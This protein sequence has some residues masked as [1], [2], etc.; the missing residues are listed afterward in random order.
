MKTDEITGS[1]RVS[2]I[3]QLPE[4][5]GEGRL[6][7]HIKTGCEIYHL[8][9]EDKENLFS[10]IFRTIPLNSKGVPH[11]L[12]HSVLSGSEKFPVKDPFV[13]LLKGSM[14]TFLNA[15]TYPDKTIYPGATIVEADYFNL[16]SVYGDAVFFPLL[17]KETFLQEGV[18]IQKNSD[19]TYEYMGVVYNEMKGAYSD[20]NSILAEWS[21]RSLFPDTSYRYDS[22]GMPE[23]IKTLGYQEFIEFHKKN[24]HPSNCKIFLYGN[25]DSEKQLDFIDKKFLSFFDKQEKSASVKAQKYIPEPVYLEKY[26][27]SDDG[28]GTTSIT[29]NWLCGDSTEPFELLSMEILGELLIGS[30]GSP[31]YLSINNSGLGEDL[32][33]VSGMDNGM[34]QTMFSVGIRGT[35]SRKRD[36]FVDLVNNSLI[37]IRDKGFDKDLLEGTLRLFEFSNR[38]IKGGRPEGLKLMELCSKAWLY[39]KDPALFLS[40]TPYMEKIRKTVLED[41][42]Y[43][44]KILNNALIQNNHRSIVTVMPDNA[45]QADISDNATLDIATKQ[46][47]DNDFSEFEKYQLCQ[48][49]AADIGKIPVLKKSDIPEKIETIECEE[50]YD[51]GLCT[52]LHGVHTAGITYTDLYYDTSLLDEELKIYLPIFSRFLRETG[53]PGIPYYE[54][55]KIFGL[56]TGG[57]YASPETGTTVYG[58][59]LEFLTLHFKSLTEKYK[60]AAEFVFNFI[61]NA[62]FDDLGRLKD[63]FKETVNDFKARIIR[64]GNYIASLYASKNYTPSLAKMEEWG[65]I[66][67]LLKLTAIN[68]EDKK[69]LEDLAQKLKKI[70]TIFSSSKVISNITSE[71]N[72]ISDCYKNLL[73]YL[74]SA[75]NGKIGDPIFASGCYTSANAS[76][77]ADNTKSNHLQKELQS[78]TSII[79][80]ALVNY[81]SAVMR[82]SRIGSNEVVYEKLL[83]RIIETGFLWENIRMK[84]GA[85]GVSASSNSM[86]GVFSFSSYRDPHIEETQ[87][88][89][90]ESLNSISASNGTILN[91]DIILKSVINS[92]GKEIRPVSPEEKGIVNALRKIYGVNDDLRQKNRDIM[93]AATTKNILDAANRL[94]AQYEAASRCVI[95]GSDP[96]KKYEKYFI[97][98]KFEKIE[99]EI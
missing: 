51:N 50:K 20:H 56:K 78:K 19:G 53:L 43:F 28:K 97:Q 38:E 34:Y 7:T 5:N 72:S 9:N 94:K 32:S 87:K 95:A 64:R 33:P 77:T 98:N 37:E 71:E 63:I 16:M 62:D 35:D 76:K 46:E 55:A 61:I 29:I 2:A 36:A 18:R 6:F 86:E 69:D 88:I 49:S 73:F 74:P 59:N 1:F 89:F 52:L 11:I 39:D 26:S 12:E 48:D 96:Y 75:S 47:V 81:N 79:V 67:Q 41:D 93:L 60:E 70:K 82:A 8:F 30:S 84:G 42:R 23:E 65:G 3:D 66:T 10:F 99:L 4:H 83:S 24:Y 13:Q 58:N 68:P 90:Y 15:I 25:I 80:P 92:V 85:Y 21:G 45:N 17:R 54:T 40:F 22:G 14:H 44:E 57:F 91:D 27:L 31:L